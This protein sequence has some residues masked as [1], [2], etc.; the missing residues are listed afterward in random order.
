MNIF[1]QVRGEFTT[2]LPHHHD[3]QTTTAPAATTP[4]PPEDNDMPDLT[5][6]ATQLAQLAA[7][8][9]ADPLIQASRQAV[10]PPGVREGHA[11]MIGRLHDA[12][13]ADQATVTAQDQA[14]AQHDQAQADTTPAPAQ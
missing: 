5:A 11:D 9:A 1:D 10:L 2:H 13:A 3:D 14:A 7:N 12:Y 6:I 8:D 4:P